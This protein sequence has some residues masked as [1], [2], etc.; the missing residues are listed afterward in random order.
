MHIIKN[1]CESLVWTLL[2]IQGKTKDGVK[3]RE[4]MVLMGIR[5]GLAPQEG[6]KRI[7][8][9]PASFTLS[10]RE[11]IS[12]LECLKSIKV[13]S[14][15][16]SNIS[17]NVAIKELKLI[18]MKSHDCHVLLTQLLPVAIRG[19]LQ[20]LHHEVVFFLQLDLLQSDRSR[21]IG[22]ITGRCRVDAM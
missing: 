17:R 11:K 16:S 3:V 19:I 9:P 18:G 8:L 5:P 13:P 15:Y 7:F 22:K 10:K 4:D 14:G 20:T 6:G 1:I 12:F 21:Y 2:N